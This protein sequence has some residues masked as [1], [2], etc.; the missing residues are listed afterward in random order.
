MVT[1]AHFK[2]Q[3]NDLTKDLT[4]EKIQ[5]LITFGHFL[6][7]RQEEFS[8]K[9]ISDSAAYVRNLRTKETKRSRSAKNYIQ[10][11]IEWQKSES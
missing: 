8:Y 7:S 4:D 5:E 11:L 1:S 6:K 2:K 10:E 3:I 9:K